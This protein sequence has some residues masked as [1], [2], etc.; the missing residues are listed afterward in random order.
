[1]A[2]AGPSVTEQLTVVVEPRDKYSL[3]GVF[4]NGELAVDEGSVE[5][6]SPDII[7]INASDALIPNLKVVLDK[8]PAYGHLEIMDRTGH[9]SFIFHF[10]LPDACYYN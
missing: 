3:T 7:S 5:I 10:N 1:M 9:S 6:L 4:V 8:Q 2:T